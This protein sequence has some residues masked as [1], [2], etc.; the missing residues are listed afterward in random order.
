MIKAVIFDWGGTLTPWMSVD[1]LA[2]WRC[3]A[4]VLHADDPER[5]AKVSA[6]LLAAEEARWAVVRKEH[7]AFTLDQVLADAAV[8]TLG[9]DAL[10]AYR[11]FW[12]PVTH[13]DP[14]AVPVLTALRDW[15]LAY[16]RECRS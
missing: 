5:S 12:L 14:E 9:R 15:G 13:T 7:R 2:G 8:T 6:V 10:D 11:S 16:R 4:D 1:H 3:L